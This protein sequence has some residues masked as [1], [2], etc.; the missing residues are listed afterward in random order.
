MPDEKKSL[1][2]FA[3]RG[4]QYGMANE[5][6]TTGAAAL[7]ASLSDEQTRALGRLLGELGIAAVEHVLS[8]RAPCPAH[9]VGTAFLLESCQCWTLDSAMQNASE[10][11]EKAAHTLTDALLALVP[12]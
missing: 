4:Y 12:Q 5:N 2:R 1:A 8:R 11:H 7:F 3:I 6:G 9:N 10:K